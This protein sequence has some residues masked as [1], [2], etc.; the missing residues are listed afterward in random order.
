M[1]VNHGY[2]SRQYTYFIN[3]KIVLYSRAMDNAMDELSDHSV[4]PMSYGFHFS[5][6]K[7]SHSRRLEN[8]KFIINIFSESK[9]V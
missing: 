2:V 1:I 9:L 7:T 6:F 4:L 5:G 8:V 3:E